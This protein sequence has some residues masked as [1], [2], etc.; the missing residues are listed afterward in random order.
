MKKRILALI[1][2]LCLCVTLSPGV[3]ALNEE[4]D[5]D[6]DTISE[7]EDM[8]TVNSPEPDITEA[9]PPN[10]PT[11]IS[12]EQAN[13]ATYDVT[14]T[15]Q[16]N[17]V[18]WK[19][20][21]VTVYGS[22]GDEIT[23]AQGRAVV[24]GLPDG[25]YAFD[26]I[27]Y[28]Y[29]TLLNQ[30]LT[31]SGEDLNITVTVPE[32]AGAKR[33]P[34]TLPVQDADGN[35]LDG[36]RVTL[37]KNGNLWASE[38]S[39]TGEV[40]FEVWETGNWD[41]IASKPGYK[42]LTAT[43]ITNG[44][45]STG[46]LSWSLFG[47]MVSN[48]RLRLADSGLPTYIVQGER[49]GDV[50][51][52]NLYLKYPDIVKVASFGLDYDEEV[53]EFQSFTLSH[54]MKI[55]EKVFSI[56]DDVYQSYQMEDHNEQKGYHIF[57]CQED[58]AGGF[59]ASGVNGQ[60]LGTYVFSIKA[61][62]PMDLSRHIDDKSFQ[63]IDFPETD[64]HDLL[65]KSDHADVTE[66]I[67]Q[68]WAMNSEDGKYYYQVGVKDLS[69]EW[70]CNWTPVTETAF[71]YSE[72]ENVRVGFKVY[73]DTEAGS[74]VVPDQSKPIAG[75]VVSIYNADGEL[76]GATTTDISGNARATLMQGNDYTY[77]VTHTEDKYWPA[78][79]GHEEAE[80]RGTIT[81]EQIRNGSAMTEI[82]FAIT[83]GMFPKTKHTVQWNL[84][85][86]A[87]GKINGA[88]S[89]TDTAT[90]YE[91]YAFRVN[92]ASGLRIK[93]NSTPTYTVTDA[94]GNVM[95]CG[96]RR[97]EDQP[98]E[99]D[100]SLNQWVIPGDDI[101]GAVTLHVE[102]ETDTFSVSMSCFQN[103]GPMET[104]TWIDDGSLFGQQIVEYFFGGHVEHEGDPTSGEINEITIGGHTFI[105][106]QDGI[107]AGD[108][109]VTF[110]TYAEEGY[111]IRFVFVEG[112]M[113]PVEDTF[114][115]TE[116]SYQFKN[117]QSDQSVVVIMTE[118]DKLD[119]NDPEKLEGTKGVYQLKAGIG[120]TISGIGYWAGNSTPTD[121]VRSGDNGGLGYA[122]T[123]SYDWT[124]FEI[125]AR[126][127]VDNNR[128]EKV[129]YVIDALYYD[130]VKIEEATG[131]TY[132]EIATENTWESHTVIATFKLN[133]P[134]TPSLQY[135]VSTNIVTG[136]GT[137]VPSGYC[138]YDAGSDVS[139]EM[140]AVELW[141]I[142]YI[143]VDGEKMELD[144]KTH[145]VDFQNIN[146]DHTVYVAFKTTAYVVGNVKIASTAQDDTGYLATGAYVEFTA[147]KDGS[148]YTYMPN[149]TDKKSEKPT[150][151][152]R[153]SHFA[154]KLPVG[155]YTLT[156]HKEGYIDYIITDFEVTKADIGN[157]IEIPTIQL[158]PG[159]ASW[160][161][162]LVSNQDMNYVILAWERPDAQELQT[163]ADIDES[164]VVDVEDISFV[165]QHYGAHK[166]DTTVTWA[167][168]KDKMA[169]S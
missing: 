72:Q 109:S 96:S 77:I 82:E 105:N 35:A 163:M 65:S 132:Y 144:T 90:Q 60:L 129:N 128:G 169:T 18:L 133:Q 111:V 9:D 136:E 153:L 154:V 16:A 157:S 2:V 25:T 50:Y 120:G 147:E 86:N 3:S 131:Q 88:V 24:C 110:H 118:T 17:G 13:D 103:S 100:T 97:L 69:D 23:D 117:V 101:I 122:V 91:D 108:D 116:F 140:E 73:E 102:F 22:S 121:F 95:N 51:T 92:M 104:W 67:N 156:V 166:S 106:R 26:V 44:V 75:A 8:E 63:V 115:R 123:G 56:G 112:A 28:G 42:D 14:F 158:V 49:S 160:D 139:I 43:I 68:I 167:E 34:L 46:L 6:G 70:Y 94:S 165:K 64:L 152:D 48:R 54:P 45:E 12:I 137:V 114:G 150:T 113:L 36:V 126:Q 78:P 151:A 162:A 135:L 37:T 84:G 71:S 59:D 58:G 146:S 99:L 61:D 79:G 80:Q 7:L 52:V 87:Q 81:A 41:L 142:D 149:S 55:C 98:A 31:I 159:D 124:V 30:S 125:S 33:Y 57:Q 89:G 5:V 53:L 47:N 155:T 11:E 145:T 83:V 107:T 134:N 74:G 76:V 4:N 138:I 164:G 39:N 127:N 20:A 161:R 143:I 19:D 130:N 66:D 40:T 15:V 85:E 148:I 62:A 38:I 141:D 21:R 168:F 93:E 119:S 29:G 1:L 32:M 27:C 10:D